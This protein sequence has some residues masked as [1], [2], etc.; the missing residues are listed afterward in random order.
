MKDIPRLARL[1]RHALPPEQDYFP[2]AVLAAESA[3][4]GLLR[5]RDK[6]SPFWRL[7]S[8]GSLFFCRRF[9]ESAS[10]LKLAMDSFPADS[11]IRRVAET[12]FGI[13][14]S[15]VHFDDGKYKII[16]T[17]QN[18]HKILKS[19]LLV[20]GRIKEPFEGF[21]LDNFWR[22]GDPAGADYEGAPLTPE[23]VASAEKQFGLKLP[24]SYIRLLEKQNGGLSVNHAGYL[25]TAQCPAEEFLFP[26]K[27]ILGLDK[28][29]K[30][31]LGRGESQNLAKKYGLDKIG[32]LICDPIAPEDGL[33]FLDY[34][35]NGKY[36][37]PSVMSATPCDDDPDVWTIDLAAKN[38][39]SFAR[40]LIPR[41]KALEERRLLDERI[42][43]DD[44]PHSFV[45]RSEYFLEIDYADYFHTIMVKLTI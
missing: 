22:P 32:L 43:N 38:F 44:V 17:P 11:E 28:K 23:M 21:D 19:V 30:Y 42:K 29:Q 37:E 36:G 33:L 25:E 10:E 35:L 3:R 39:E 9:A 12:L 1:M 13:A 40:N 41:E 18:F 34:R 27:A 5:V 16:K 20:N 14:E 8:G 45:H 4:A 2:G 24:L 6:S 26:F 15:N 7:L 31:S